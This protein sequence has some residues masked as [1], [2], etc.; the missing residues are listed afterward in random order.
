MTETPNLYEH[1]GRLNME[2]DGLKK[3]CLKQLNRGVRLLNQVT[4][5]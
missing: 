3:S 5:I 4:Q 2:L 1:I